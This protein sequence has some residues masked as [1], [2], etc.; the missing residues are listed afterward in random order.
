M[1]PYY[2]VFYSKAI[3]RQL[4]D[5]GGFFGIN[6]DGLSGLDLA[7]AVSRGMMDFNHSIGAPTKLTDIGGFVHDVHVPRAMEAAKDPSLKM[8]LQNMPVPM[9]ANDVD[10]YMAGILEAACTGDLNLI[11]QM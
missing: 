5:L 11:K 8:K 9:T 1:N 10:T 4:V 6:V 3:Q 2:A 7:V